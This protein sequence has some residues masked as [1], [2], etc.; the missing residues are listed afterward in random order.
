MSPIATPYASSAPDRPSGLPDRTSRP[1]FPGHERSLVGTVRSP[2]AVRRACW[3]SG[4]ERRPAGGDRR[5]PHPSPRTHGHVQLVRWA[6][7][8]AREQGGDARRVDVRRHDDIGALR[9]AARAGSGQSRAD[10]SG[11]RR[12][13][14]VATPQSRARRGTSRR[15]APQ[16]TPGA[17]PTSSHQA[18]QRIP[19]APGRSEEA[20]WSDQA[21]PST[22]V[23]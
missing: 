16:R 13:R 19:T 1:D 5:C 20:A 15:Q 6:R 4:S 23:G 8:S 17:A 21:V 3:G 22:T 12:R 9:H 7:R 11:R 2:T 14:A 18:D 10:H